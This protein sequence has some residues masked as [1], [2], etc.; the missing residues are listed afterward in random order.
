MGKPAV[1]VIRVRK[2]VTVI[3]LVLLSGAMVAMLAY[4]SGRA[5][6][7]GHEPL[8]D[9][10]MRVMQRSGDVTRNAILAS[11]MPSIANI[12]FFM[13]WG[14]LMFLA[15]DSPSRARSRTYLLTVFVGALFAIAMQVWQSFLPTRVFGPADVVGDTIGALAG[16]M[17]G[18]LRKRVRVQFDY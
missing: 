16:A 14:F 10:L 8:R 9:L 7:S 13:P 5:Y 15:L 17:A 11:V 1:H 18:H 6:S 2:W 4:L 3:L 12:L